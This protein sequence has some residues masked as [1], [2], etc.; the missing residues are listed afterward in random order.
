MS[1]SIIDF[2]NCHTEKENGDNK[3]I[4]DKF[5][6]VKEI[7]S[8]DTYI[9]KSLN[10]KGVVPAN[11]ILSTD[12]NFNVVGSGSSLFSPA[13]WSYNNGI[14]PFLIPAN[15]ITQLDIAKSGTLLEQTPNMSYN[16]STFILNIADRGIYFFTC[17]YEVRVNVNATI[18]SVQV[19]FENVIPPLPTRVFR[20]GEIRETSTL[21]DTRIMTGSFIAS[22]AG[23]SLGNWR[24]MM[25]NQYPTQTITITN[26]NTSVYKIANIP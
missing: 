7:N 17:S 6:D 5:L 19:D 16:G 4:N 24:I 13:Y 26:M 2:V 1:S 23:G 12:A 15:A 10:L 25:N 3:Y 18:A 14:N 8:E 21:N 20:I 9:S 22:N 11:N